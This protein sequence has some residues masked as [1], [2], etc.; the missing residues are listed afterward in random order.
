MSVKIKRQM[1]YL[2]AH[3]AQPYVKIKLVNIL[4]KLYNSEK[5][6]LHNIVTG[7]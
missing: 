3:E 6:K 1:K 4:K 7:S 5:I 2:L